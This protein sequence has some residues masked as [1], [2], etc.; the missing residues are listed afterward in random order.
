[1][2]AKIGVVERLPPVIGKVS[3]LRTRLTRQ[4]DRGTDLVARLSAAEDVLASIP[5]KEK[6]GGLSLEAFH[7]ISAMHGQAEPV[8]RSYDAWDAANL[9]LLRDYFGAEGDRLYR[10]AAAPAIAR[11]LR[12]LDI[13]NLRHVINVRLGELRAVG[14][15]L[16][17]RDSPASAPAEPVNLDLVRS[18]KLVDDEVLDRLEERIRGLR[19]RRNVPRVIGASKELVEA[20]SHGALHVLGA[21]PVTGGDFGALT[22]RARKEL[23]GRIAG[24]SP[25]S[26]ALEASA[27]KLLAGLTT[28][29]QGL[30]EIR[31][32]YGE[33]HG[34]R[35]AANGLQVRHGRLAAEAAL[36]YSHYVVY[37]LRDLGLA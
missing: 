35:T 4:L 33:G 15:L 24:A 36:T 31:N 22:K 29:E 20:V 37:A 17:T 6:A 30:A 1:L 12:E 13:G 32:A 21:A 23:A 11:P 3:G 26:A 9:R 8:R 25:D 18:A 19:D 27:V 14:D 5:K 2:W 34:R 7:R 10:I 16:P 28:I